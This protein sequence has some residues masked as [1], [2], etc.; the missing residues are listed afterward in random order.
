MVAPDEGSSTRPLPDGVRIRPYVFFDDYELRNFRCANPGEPWTLAAEMT[1]QHEV[2]PLVR[3]GDAFVLVA[4]LEGTVVGVIA[5]GKNPNRPEQATSLVLAVAPEHRR[6][7]VGFNLKLA[8]AR[9]CSA[10][11]IRI[12]TSE[13]DVHIE[14]MR[15]CNA[16]FGAVTVPEPDDPE[17]L[18]NIVRIG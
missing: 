5:I 9:I 17:M 2:V 14:P 13:V 8:A 1:V 15:E 7:Y 4:E 3:S 10:H 12:I 18:L 6:R 11:G 16:C